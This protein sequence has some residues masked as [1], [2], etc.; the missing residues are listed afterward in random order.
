MQYNMSL[1]PSVASAMEDTPGAQVRISLNVC[2]PSPIH[3]DLLVLGRIPSCTDHPARDHSIAAQ[4]LVWRIKQD[5]F[6]GVSSQQ[7]Q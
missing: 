7:Y 4:C 5:K 2:C 6:E 3:E 1:P